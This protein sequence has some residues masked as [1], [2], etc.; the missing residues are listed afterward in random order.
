M[1]GITRI[2][3]SSASNHRRAT[4]ICKYKFDEERD[5]NPFQ[6]G[7]KVEENLGQLHVL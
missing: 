4:S 1:K 7:A 5:P 2:N 3:S 6:L